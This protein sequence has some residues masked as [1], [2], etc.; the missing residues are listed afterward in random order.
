MQEVYYVPSGIQD[1]ISF[2][3]LETIEED[4]NY[5]RTRYVSF[6]MNN[7]STVEHNNYWICKHNE[8]NMT[9]PELGPLI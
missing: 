8:Q 5:V 1:R 7:G 3:Y 9:C 2:Y 4:P 6:D